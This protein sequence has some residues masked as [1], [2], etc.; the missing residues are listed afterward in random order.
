MITMP[1]P[2]A[3]DVE[4]DEGEGHTLIEQEPRH[5][6]FKRSL[7]KSRKKFNFVIRHFQ[8]KINH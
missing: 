7:A 2:T 3:K 6:I 1:Q 8:K 5:K 4:H